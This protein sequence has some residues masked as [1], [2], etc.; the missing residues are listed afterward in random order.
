MRAGPPSYCDRCRKVRHPTRAAARL[1]IRRLERSGRADEHPRADE[2]LNVYRCPCGPG[3]HV[4]HS[5]EVKPW[6]KRRRA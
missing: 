4:G 5:G 3:W 2:L 6:I 1:A